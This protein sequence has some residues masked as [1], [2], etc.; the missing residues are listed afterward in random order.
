MP[1][2]DFLAGSVLFALMLL[3]VLGVTALIVRR[4]LAHLDRLERALAAIVVATAILVAV[5]VVPLLLGILDEATVLATTALA[6]LLATRVKQADPGAPEDR[7]PPPPPSGR[8]DRALAAGASA[9]AL[10][11]A[12]ADLR[13]WAANEIVGVDPLTF[14]LPNIGRWIQTGSLWQIDQ[15]VPLLAHGNYPNNGDVVMLG[16]V[17]P[18]HNDFLVRAPICFFLAVTAVAVAAV[19]RELRAPAAASVLA[20]AALV[21]VPIVGLATIPRALPDSLLWATFTCGV[22]FLLRHARTSRR[23]DLMLAATALAI[24]FGTKWYGLSSVGVLVAVWIAARLWQRDI[25]KARALRDSLLLGG[26]VAIGDL[27]WMARNVVESANPFFPAKIAAFGVT[28][29]DAPRDVV[30]E[31][32]G[33]SILDY[34]GDP[35]V[36]TVLAGEVFDG[37]GLFA[38]VCAAGLIAAALVNRRPLD[39]RVVLLSIAAI[40][41]V[42]VY[43]ALPGTALGNPGDPSLASVNT[44]YAIPSLLLAAPVVAWIIGRVPRLVALAF[45]LALTVAVVAGAYSGYEVQGARDVVLAAVGLALVAAVGW[46]LWRVRRRRRLVV[47]AATVVA[48]AG[49]AA[50]HRVEQR[51]NTERYL[52]VDPAIDVLLRAAPSGKRIGLASDWSVSG[53]SPIWPSFGTR[54]GNHVEYIGYFDGFLR[55]YP[56]RR[57]F[58][59]ALR[60]GRYDA[61]VVGRGFYPPQPTPEQR[62]AAEAGWRTIALSTRLRVLIPSA[63]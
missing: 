5:H 48:L 51:I 20:A 32:V 52:G 53:L 59:D 9:V 26:L 54:I 34:V 49:L 25:P 22:L 36:L 2:T 29:F 23:S 15:F 8:L 13:R 7:G 17:L 19:A 43:A 30:V 37:L 60:R 12:I 38:I 35:T 21:S 3:G 6:A 28:I 4:R 46:A 55:R 1:L 63:R 62:W 45:E 24:A 11:A 27:A 50:A 42:P 31:A 16:T 14:H 57:R 41:L 33:F 40:A 61:I 18:W 39:R 56:T 10:T 58:Q 47:A 44:R